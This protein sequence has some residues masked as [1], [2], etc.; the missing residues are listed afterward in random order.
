VLVDACA[1]RQSTEKTLE[2]SL[3]PY[4]HYDFTNVFG[5]CCE[6]VIGYMPVPVGVAGPYKVD[7]RLYHIPMATTEGC[8]VASAARGCKAITQGSGATTVITRDGITRGPV[9]QFPSIVRAAECQHW[10]EHE[11]W[12]TIKEAFESTSRFAKLQRLR[13]ALAGRL[14]FIRFV[15]QTADAMGMNMVS[16][17]SEEALRVLQTVFSD[18]DII[19]LSGNYC[20]DKK[21][22]AVNWIEGRGKSVVSEAVIPGDVVERT[23]KTNVAALV[24]LNQSKNLVG[25]AMAGSIGGF[26]AHA[27]NII[28]AIY[29]A[30]GQD[31]AQNV[32]SSNCI[33]LMNRLEGTARCSVHVGVAD[34]GALS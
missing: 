30:T 6:N 20:S 24:E 22:A 10:L 14:V 16:K 15:T 19:A 18:M 31:P 27:S 32:E 17:G 28:T 21:P 5:R 13:V 11:G 26:N 12:P 34:G 8:L 33:T 7:G 1:A 3:L 4:E 25:S 9:V 23:L 29:I 2:H